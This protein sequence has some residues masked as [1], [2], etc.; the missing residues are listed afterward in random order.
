MAMSYFT[1]QQDTRKHNALCSSKNR[2]Q[3][4]FLAHWKSLLDFCWSIKTESWRVIRNVNPE[5][6]PRGE[7]SIVEQREVKGWV[8]KWKVYVGSSLQLRKLCIMNWLSTQIAIYSQREK[9]CG[10]FPN[11]VSIIWSCRKRAVWF[12]SN[13]KSN[14][15]LLHWFVHWQPGFERIPFPGAYGARVFRSA[16]SLFFCFRH[17]ISKEKDCDGQITS[18]CEGHPVDTPSIRTP[19]SWKGWVQLISVWLGFYKDFRCLFFFNYLYD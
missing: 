11:E 15:P 12:W 14:G 7:K 19:D 17:Q 10:C 4:H 16:K 18:K 5:C 8:E 13:D 6:W 2:S 1:T 9:G 3:I